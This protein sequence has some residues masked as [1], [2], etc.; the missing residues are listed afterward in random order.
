LKI[1]YKIHREYGKGTIGMNWRREWRMCWFLKGRLVEEEVFDPTNYS[2]CASPVVPVV[3][4]NGKIRLC[5]DYKA[6]K[7]LMMCTLYQQLTKFWQN[8]RRKLTQVRVNEST[9]QVLTLNTHR[10]LYKIHRLPFGSES[11]PTIFRRLMESVLPN[12]KG[13]AV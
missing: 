9:S 1:R 10:G 6:T 2:E 8:G 5:G 13:T 7:H 3:K 12:L 4:G 11:A